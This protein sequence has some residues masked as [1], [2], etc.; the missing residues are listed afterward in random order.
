MLAIWFDMSQQGLQCMEPLIRGQPPKIGQN[1]A[2]PKVSFIFYLD[3]TLYS[4]W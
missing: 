2:A 3:I 4:A 1:F